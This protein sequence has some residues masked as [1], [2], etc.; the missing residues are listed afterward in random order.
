MKAAE[1]GHDQIVSLL[2][3]KKADLSAANSKGR[4]ALSFAA[5]PSR[6]RSPSIPTVRLL[7]ECGANLSHRDSLGMTAKERAKK[8]KRHEAVACLEEFEAQPR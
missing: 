5:A 4:D 1:E 7:I 6:N 2:I 3:G 8:E